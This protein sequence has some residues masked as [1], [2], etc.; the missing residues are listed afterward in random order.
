MDARRV[1]AAVRALGILDRM[2][3][4]PAMV[5]EYET[6]ERTRQALRRLPRY[7]VVLHNDAINRMDDVVRALLQAVPPL[8]RAEA[9]R[10]MLRAHLRG[11]SGVVICPREQAEHYREGLARHGL[12]VSIHPTRHA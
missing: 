7:R 6:D 9:V 12:N 1:G 3:P 8:S 11:A 4:H 10:V 2:A 5:T